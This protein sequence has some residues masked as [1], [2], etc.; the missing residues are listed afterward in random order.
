MNVCQQFGIHFFIDVYWPH[1][2]SDQLDIWHGGILWYSEEVYFIFDVGGV[3]VAMVTFVLWNCQLFG[4]H[5]FNVCQQFDIHFFIDVYWPHFSDQLDIWNG[6]LSWYSEEAY[7]VFGVGGV[8]VAMVTMVFV[9]IEI[10][11]FSLSLSL[12]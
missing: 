7:F 3:I 10:V 2:F 11:L 8:I 4:I 12:V 5:F 6:G 9:E 1:F